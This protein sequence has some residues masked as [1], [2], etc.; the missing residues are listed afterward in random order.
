[1]VVNNIGLLCGSLFCSGSLRTSFRDALAASLV[2][3]CCLNIH[4]GGFHSLLQSGSFLRSHR[5]RRSPLRYLRTGAAKPET[6]ATKLVQFR[7]Y[8]A[9]FVLYCIPLSGGACFS[10]SVTTDFLP[11]PIT[12]NRLRLPLP[13]PPP[14]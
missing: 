14:R 8:R 6:G 4:G 9:A 3:I 11:Q 5:P 7:F 12:F 1:M 13:P 10:G 2:F